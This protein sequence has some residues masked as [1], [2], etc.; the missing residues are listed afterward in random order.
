MQIDTHPRIWK[1]DVIPLEVL[2]LVERSNHIQILQDHDN[3]INHPEQE[4]A[5]NG[6]ME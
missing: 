2:E 5:I 6:A 4:N 1:D 3:L